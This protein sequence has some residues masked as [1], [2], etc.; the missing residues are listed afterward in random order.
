MANKH[1]F[2][3]APQVRNH[4]GGK[5]HR[6]SSEEILASLAT[7]GT[8]SDTYYATGGDQ[9][10]LIQQHAKNVDDEFLAKLALYSRN[11]AYMKD[12]PAFLCAMLI[13]RQSEYAEAVFD[14]VIDNARM[15]RNF[16]QMIR[17][18]AVGRK[19]LGSRAKRLVKKFI[20]NMGDYALWQ[21]SIGN[22]PSLVDV[23]KLAHPKA[24][25]ERRN[26]LYGYIMGK[27]VDVAM[28]PDF[29]QEYE[30]FVNG[31]SREA[32]LNAPFQKLTALPLTTR[33]WTNIAVRAKWQMTRMNLNTFNRHG[34]FEDP[35]MIQM[36]V[37]RLQDRE[38]IVSARAFP[39]QLMTAALNVNEDMPYEIRGALEAAM[40][41]AIENTP[42]IPGEK[43]CIAIDVSGSMSRP[44][45]GLF[46]TK[47][48]NVTCL[49]A[50]ALIGSALR[51]KNHDAMILTFDYTARELKVHRDAKV[52]TIATKIKAK[53]GG[54]TNCGSVIQYLLDKDIAVD[55]LIMVS[56]NE[57]WADGWRSELSQLWVRYKKYH[58]KARMINCDITP[59]EYSASSERADTLRVAGF[60]DE[61]FNVMAAFL[62]GGSNQVEAIKK[63]EIFGKKGVD[64][65]A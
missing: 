7:T 14:G 58:P 63:V 15:L 59:N 27:P 25:D 16:V 51:R 33:E 31:N 1:V 26:A 41:I 55:N 64:E 39:Y 30:A 22:D 24:K 9:L 21:A 18:G 50:A 61:V 52:M 38:S 19:S 2:G 57:S 45:T 47:S 48:S 44:V 42:E 6:K 23:I 53:L 29:I 32:P 35:A 60:S 4:A 10:D 3:S 13:A 65:V 28:L 20:S 11:N 62:G 56:D 46:T 8:F 54:G 12:M 5:S 37:D 36:I 34:V 17:S 43:T 49:D 40:E